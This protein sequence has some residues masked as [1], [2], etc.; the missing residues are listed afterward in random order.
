MLASQWMRLQGLRS[1]H[2]GAQALQKNL[3][4]IVCVLANIAE[5]ETSSSCKYVMMMQMVVAIG[6]DGVLMTT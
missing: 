1:S 5:P 2:A 3:K 4:A 6:P